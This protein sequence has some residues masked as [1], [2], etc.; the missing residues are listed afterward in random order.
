[1]GVV[2]M[3]LVEVRDRVE[4][5]GHVPHG[6]VV[7]M[8]RERNITASEVEIC[9]KKPTRLPKRNSSTVSAPAGSGGM[10]TE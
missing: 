2:G 10:F 3:D 8:P 9:W 4:A 5:P 6:L 7:G 1:M